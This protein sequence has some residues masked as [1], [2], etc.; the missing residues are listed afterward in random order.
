[1]RVD[2]A[3]R[4]RAEGLLASAGATVWIDDEALMDAVTGT[5]GSGPAYVFLLAEAMEEAAIA[6]GLAAD[7]ARALVRHT[8]LGAARM[9]VESGRR[10]TAP[11]GT[12]QAAIEACEAGDLRRLVARAVR[13]A[14]RR[15]G[16]LSAGNA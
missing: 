1:P 14:T 4:A 12:T 11:G 10:D 3:G 2:A 6:E 7:A 9:L 13:A 16:E 8:I 15:G 5:S